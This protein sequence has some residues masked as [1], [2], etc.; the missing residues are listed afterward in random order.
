VALDVIAHI[1][2]LP[3]LR[4]V[5]NGTC[6]VESVLHRGTFDLGVFSI[7]DL[8]EMYGISGELTQLP[9]LLEF[10]SIDLCVGPDGE[11]NNMA[12]LLIIPR[13]IV[14]PDFNIVC[15]QPDFSTHFDRVDDSTCLRVVLCVCLVGLH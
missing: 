5:V 6:T 15:E 11:D 3:Q 9:H 4:G 2:L 14:S 1:P 7:A 12:A 8:V 10:D 13:V